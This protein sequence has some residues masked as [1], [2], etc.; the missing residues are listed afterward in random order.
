MAYTVLY[1]GMM[2][3]FILDFKKLISVQFFFFFPVS[4]TKNEE[5]KGLVSSSKDKRIGVENHFTAKGL[6]HNLRNT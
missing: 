4:N 1:L 5:G 2:W 3:N 6:E